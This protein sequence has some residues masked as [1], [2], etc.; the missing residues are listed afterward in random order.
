MAVIYYFSATG[1]S[2]DVA[3][4]LA[5]KLEDAR[6]APL[7]PLASGN[8]AADDE[9][10]GL[11]FPVYDWNMPL[12]VR[13]FLTRLD[14]SKAGYIFAVATCN[15]LPGQALERVKEIL[16]S[17]GKRLGAGFIV[18]MPGTYLPF[19][20]ANSHGVQRR[21]F[22]KMSRKTD[23]IARIVRDRRERAIEKSHMMFDRLLGPNMEANME[24]FYEKDKMFAVSPECSGCGTCARVCC[25]NNIVMKDNRPQWLHKCQQCF[26]CIHLCPKN[27][28]EIGD[29][30]QG[31][32]RYKNPAVSLK[33]II[34]M[35]NECK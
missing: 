8:P 17:K 18:R 12:V 23:M 31:R 14:V 22:A 24:C 26:A 27:C 34:S 25:F 1:N 15:F 7:V 10:I 4:T 20:G 16:T 32:E 11:I 3:R 33:E 5:G 28:I 21:K 13:D 19:Y 9:T 30:T 29:K 35:A 2:Y 6:L